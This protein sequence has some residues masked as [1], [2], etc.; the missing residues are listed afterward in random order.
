MKCYFHCKNQSLTHLLSFD[1]V[2]N[3]HLSW[4]I[5]LPLSSFA[6]LYSVE[7][8]ARGRVLC[9]P[10]MLQTLPDHHSH[11]YS[12]KTDIMLALH[13]IYMCSL[14]II[15]QIFCIQQDHLCCHTSR[16]TCT[17]MSISN[18]DIINTSQLSSL[19]H[20]KPFLWKK[21]RPKHA[22][23]TTVKYIS[24]LSDWESTFWHCT[25]YIY[26]ISLFPH[27]HTPF[28]PSLI[29]LMVSVDVKH[30]VYYILLVHVFG[31]VKNNT[32]ITIQW[33][34]Q[35]W[36]LLNLCVKHRPILLSF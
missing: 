28:S 8:S 19:V 27:L 25:I 10:V 36:K 20:T 24:F 21:E 7:L 26:I 14:N 16:V 32:K 15:S 11:H 9:A 3:K 6:L 2:L 12:V 18:S 4:Q 33:S 30:H 5:K 23:I 29:S 1:L 22:P 34:D 17:L 13:N 31:K 35:Y